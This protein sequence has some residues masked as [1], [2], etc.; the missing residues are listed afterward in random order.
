MADLLSTLLV[1]AAVLTVLGWRVPW[2]GP[3]WVAIAIG[4]AIIPDLGRLSL[5]VEAT[6]VEGVLGL[7]FA[8]HAVETLG[9]VLLVAGLI[10]VAFERSLWSRVYA[11]LVGGGL[12]HLV[13][14]S[15]RV[16]ASGRAGEWLFPLV[17]GYRPPAPNL[18][19]SSDPAVL[20]VAFVV[21]GGV[22]LTDRVIIADGVW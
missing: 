14:D 19:V 7:P 20:G 13:L 2:I 11:S 12:V 6:T 4:G 10:T 16:Y 3:R 1:T 5:V 8:Y 21:A 9:G 15:L 17:P 22:L 18:F